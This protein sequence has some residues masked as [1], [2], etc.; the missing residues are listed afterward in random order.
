MNKLLDGLK[1]KANLTTTENGALTHKTSKSYVLDY[2]AQ[3]SALRNRDEDSIISLFNDAFQ[4]DSLLAMKVLFNSRDV[5]GGQGE[6]KTF[7]TIIN[8]LAINNPEVI[9][10]NIEF[11]PFF[12]RWDDLYALFN[13]PLEKKAIELIKKQLDEDIKSD[14][15]SLCA[16]WLA[17]ENASSKQTKEL[18]T[19]TRIGLKMTSKQYRKMLSSLRKK[20]KIIET[21][22]TNKDYSSIEYDK[23]PSQAGLKYKSCFWENDRERYSKFLESV[24]KGEKKINVGTLSPYEIVSKVP[25]YN[26][27]G[28]NR[29]LSLEERKTLNTMWEQ[30]PDYVEDKFE[31]A[32]AVVDVSGSM[33]GTPMDIAIS[34]GLYLAEKSKGEFANHFITFESNPTLVEIKGKDFVEKVQN[35]SRASWGGSTNIKKVFNLILKTAIKKQITQSEMPSRI[36]IISDMEFDMAQDLYYEYDN[37]DYAPLFETIKEEFKDAGYEMP[38]LVFWNADSRQNNI[39]MTMDE[40]VQLVSGASPRLFTQVLKDYSAYELMLEVLNDKRYDCVTV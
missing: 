32:I 26:C 39:P 22:I 9:E 8:N 10:K 34:L 12:G 31:N 2:F 30:L 28:G 24:N 6:R 20:I 18:A 5:R 16:K 7:R 25:K 40:N 38:R 33:E 35:I 3:G 19:K 17:S 23:V 13:T 11:I 4:E 14:N 36:I 15:P 27:W 1:E 29:E 37:Y 21:L